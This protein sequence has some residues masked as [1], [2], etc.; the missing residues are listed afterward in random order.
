M[1]ATDLRVR[2][3]TSTDA[4]IPC[5]ARSERRPWC[6]VDSGAAPGWSDRKSVCRA[7]VLI[8]S[9]VR[10]TSTTRLDAV[11]NTVSQTGRRTNRGT[12]RIVHAS[13]YIWTHAYRTLLLCSRVSIFKYSCGFTLSDMRC[14]FVLETAV[15]SDTPPSR[16]L[17]VVRRE[18]G[19]RM[20]DACVRRVQHSTST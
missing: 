8:E 15:M 3:E 5:R 12:I 19:V 4:V 16:G 9:L 6:A 14:G 1:F 20:H 18:R 10:D 7:K 2:C 13:F 11:A 17:L